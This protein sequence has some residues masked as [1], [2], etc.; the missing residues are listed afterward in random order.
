MTEESLVILKF[1]GSVLAG[2]AS[3][4][5]AVAEVSR[6][7]ASYPRVVAVVSAFKNQTDALERNAHALC[8]EPAPEALAFYMGLGEMRSAAELTIALQ[9][10][11]VAATL[12]MPWDVAMRSEGHP[13][14]ALPVAVSRQS[15]LHALAGNRVLVFPGYVGRGHDGEPHVLGRGGSDLTAIFLAAELEADRCILLKDTPGIFEW[16]P[17]HPGERPRR[18]LRIRYDDA[19]RCGGRVLRPEHVAYARARGVVV[20]VTAVGA[21]LATTVGTDTSEIEPSAPLEK[22]K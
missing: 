10:A 14:E 1:G 9:A 2:E 6:Y 4:P 13:L 15:F 12:R 5:A 3:I 16:D 7:L 11:G 22:S 20:E 18:Y 17:A 21:S 19:E 8:A